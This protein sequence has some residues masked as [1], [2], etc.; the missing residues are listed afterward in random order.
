[1]AVAGDSVGGNM[2]AAVTLLAKERGGPKLRAQVLFYPATNANFAD[3]SYN[4][5]A[6]GPWLTR[7]AMKWFWDAY[8]PNVADREKITASPLRASIDE[9][10]DCRGARHHR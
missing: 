3:G 8:A 5:F 9:L 1:M 7:A 6:D 4:E 2:A 10:R